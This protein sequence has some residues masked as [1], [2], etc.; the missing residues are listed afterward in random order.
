[1]YFVHS[2]DMLLWDVKSGRWQVFE[3]QSSSACHNRL[4]F[5]ITQGGPENTNIITTSLD[6][7][8]KFNYNATVQLFMNYAH[9][10]YV[11]FGCNYL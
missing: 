8:V 10:C 9:S 6:R 7:K 4:I 5:T 1:M 11:L 3:T 2:G